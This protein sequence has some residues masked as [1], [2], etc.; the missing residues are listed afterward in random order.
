MTQKK[1]IHLIIYIMI[2]IN[3]SSC[4][5]YLELNAPS[6]QVGS[7]K[8]FTSEATATS[9]VNGIYSEMMNSAN[10]FTNNAVTLYAGMAADEMYYYQ[11]DI[12]DEFIQNNISPANH[13]TLSLIFWAPS[14]KYIYIANLILEKLNGSS[15]LSMTIKNR[16]VG[17]CKF[18]RAFCYF[19]LVNLFGDIPLCLTSD[20]RVNQTLSRSSTHDVYIQIIKDLRDAKDL[21]QVEYSQ[22]G[23]CTPNRWAV[24]ALLAKAYLYTRNWDKAEEEASSIINSG[25]YSLNTNLNEVFLKTSS[26]TIW[27]LAPVLPSRNTWEGFMILPSSNSSVP[28]YLLTSTLL[29]AFEPGDA[30]KVAWINTRLYSGQTLYYPFKYRIRSG[31]VVDEYY[32][33]FRLA[34]QY[35]IRAEARAQLLNIQGAVSDLNLIRLRCGLAPFLNTIDQVTCLVGIEG[36]RKLELFSEWGNRWFDLKRTGR[37]DF[38]LGNLKPGSWQPSDSLWPIPIDQINLNSSLTQNPGY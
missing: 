11:P 15:S 9:A 36:E 19:Y 31:T 3:N 23:R 17:E 24:T 14:Y 18:I 37:A 16:L 38:I 8:V 6:D 32:I 20:Y 21:V 26:E 12:K 25:V 35:L 30:R 29:N 5:K 33:V 34:E 7:E 10:Q 22:N 2:V 13:S 28:S 4:K 1:F 27:Q